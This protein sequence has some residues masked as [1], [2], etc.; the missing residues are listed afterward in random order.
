MTQNT[1]A[2][3]LA[4]LLVAAIPGL[5]DTKIVTSYTTDGQAVITTIYA[6]GQRVRYDYGKGL[7]L[8]RQC[9]LKR[10]VQLDEQGK[11]FLSLPEEPAGVGSAPKTQV[12]DTGESKEMFGYSAR[13]LKMTKVTEGKK[14]R[15]DTDGWYMDLKDMAVCSGQD[16]H[17]ETQ[18]YP[19]EYT[20]TTF[21]ENGKP[22]SKVA[23]SVTAIAPD[24]LDAALFEIPAGYKDIG[25]Q[26]VA[27][28]PA[29]MVRIGTI[30]LQNQFSAQVQGA[31]PYNRL[32]AA[33]RDAKL[34]V[35]PLGDATPEALEQ[36]ARD[37]QCDY[38]LFTELASLE[39]PATNKIGGMLKKAGSVSHVTNG[40]AIEAHV[41]YRLVP[42]S[43]GTAVLNSSAIGRMG[44]SINWKNTAMLASNLLPMTMAAKFIGGSGALN[45][46][47]MSS[48]LSGNSAGSSMASVDP[49]MSG[50]SMFLRA[51]NLG[52]G[53]AA[54]ASEANAYAAAALT[55]ALDLE[56][57][58]IVSQLKP[59]AK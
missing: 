51:A 45:P 36:K 1:S 22:V 23:M 2:S 38:I 4:V 20:I 59:A 6:K 49:M 35:I 10:M 24:P 43:G 21:G 18:G 41:N 8:L 25:I 44:G 58:A 14:E 46:A 32:F 39:K 54:N 13:H 48:L 9:D 27:E 31:G 30:P 33:L 53:G 42:V 5:S 47:M 34:D 28:K 15:T 16:S 40:E 26:A 52:Q 3:V 56:A 12:T 37:K 19:S 55:A 29:G 11:T 50:I 7:I 57:K 17:A